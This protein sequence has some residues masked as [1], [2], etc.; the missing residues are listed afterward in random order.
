[1]DGKIRQKRGKFCPAFPFKEEVE[2][3]EKCKGF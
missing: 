3:D 2:D 1:M